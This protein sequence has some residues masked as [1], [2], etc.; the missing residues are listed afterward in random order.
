MTV[1]AKTPRLSI[2]THYRVVPKAD[3][4]VV[5]TIHDGRTKVVGVFPTE[6]EAEARIREYYE[7]WTRRREAWE[8]D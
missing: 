7:E 4:W 6:Q 1:P 5:E 2:G 8:D 3:A